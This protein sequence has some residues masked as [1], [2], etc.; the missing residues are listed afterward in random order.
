MN[1]GCINGHPNYAKKDP[2]D[3]FLA[4]EEETEL[5]ALNC[6]HPDP[7]VSLA[8]TVG[9]SEIMYQVIQVEALSISHDMLQPKHVY[10]GL[11]DL[12]LT[13]NS[14][15]EKRIKEQTKW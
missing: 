7:R 2:T 1:S 8:P 9:P 5:E 12:D 3:F 11:S 13:S 4:Q 10:L 6:A 15:D 14:Q